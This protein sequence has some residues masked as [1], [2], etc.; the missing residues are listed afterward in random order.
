MVFHVEQGGT[1]ILTATLY[2]VLFISDEREGCG[3]VGKSSKKQRLREQQMIERS[4]SYAYGVHAKRRMGL[5]HDVEINHQARREM[6]FAIQGK[7][8]YGG[9]ARP[10]GGKQNGR[11]RWHVWYQGTWYP[12]VYDSSSKNIVTVLPEGA[13][14]EAPKQPRPSKR[15][16]L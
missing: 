15:R 9:C 8:G 12:V 1:S 13:L 6:V 3:S 16:L 2:T 4:K 7:H 10:V 14:G 5:R 11:S